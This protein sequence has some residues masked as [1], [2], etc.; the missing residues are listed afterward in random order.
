MMPHIWWGKRPPCGPGYVGD[1]DG[2][3]DG[4]G[5]A[6]TCT[7]VIVTVTVLGSAV[8][9]C[10]G[11][12]CTMRETVPVTPLSEM[13]DV[14]TESRALS[15]SCGPDSTTVAGFTLIA[16]SCHPDGGVPDRLGTTALA[17]D[18]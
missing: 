13:V 11:V 7:S 6:V 2:W 15:S 4:D 10:G 16:T 14:E 9:P 3:A 5:L 1:G 17:R 8:T 18:V 12:T